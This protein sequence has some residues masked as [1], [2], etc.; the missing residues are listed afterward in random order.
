MSIRM[1]SK[2]AA[3]DLPKFHQGESKS[4]A[5]YLSVLAFPVLGENLPRSIPM[6]GEG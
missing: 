1:E 2:H 6:R 3:P 5:R 4:G